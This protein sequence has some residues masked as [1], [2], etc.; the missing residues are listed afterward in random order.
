MLKKLLIVDDDGSLRRLYRRIFAGRG[1]RFTLAKS[2]AEA[3]A[4]LTSGSYDLLITD[5]LLG[6]GEG[7]ELL[8]L[9]E[10]AGKNTKAMVVS[11]SMGPAERTLL[12]ERYNLTN[13]FNKPFDSLTLLAAVKRILD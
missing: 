1:Y 5:Y 3:R 2:A 4:L 10:G 6:D 11:G 12:A 8:D 7:T 13:C 9:L